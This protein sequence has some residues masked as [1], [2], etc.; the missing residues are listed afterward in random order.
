MLPWEDCILC[1]L[2]RTVFCAP[3]GGLCLELSRHQQLAQNVDVDFGGLGRNCTL[4]SLGRTVRCAL[5]AST[6]GAER[7]RRLWGPW[8]ELYLCSLG[9]T[10]LC[11]LKASEVDTEM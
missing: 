11:A 2:G 7:R 4:C 10:V 9:M 1:S 8:K 3:L 5:K 6:V